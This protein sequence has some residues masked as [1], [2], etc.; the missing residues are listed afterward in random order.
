MFSLR[1]SA[2]GAINDLPQAFPR[3]VYEL[4]AAR[5][6]LQRDFLAAWGHRFYVRLFDLTR[7]RGLLVGHGEHRSAYLL[8]ELLGAG[9]RIYKLLSKITSEVE[10]RLNGLRLAR[11]I[12]RELDYCLLWSF[13]T[14]VGNREN[15]C[16]QVRAV[17]IPGL[18]D[19]AISIIIRES[20]PVGAR[21]N[22]LARHLDSFAEG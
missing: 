19:V 6:V 20:E 14:V 1:G 8:R 7:D 21:G 12:L 17:P 15:R 16:Q 5:R 11:R 2:K 4:L 9:L 10:P 22:N 3:V 18:N 13:L